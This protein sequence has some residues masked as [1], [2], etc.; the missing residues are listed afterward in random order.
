MLMAFSMSP[1]DSTSAARQ[2]LKPAPVRSRNSLTRCAGI[3]MAGCCVL[4]FFSFLVLESLYRGSRAVRCVCLQ[5]GPAHGLCHSAGPVEILCQRDLLTWI[6]RREERLF[7]Q[8]RELPAL[9]RALPLRRNLLPASL[10]AL[11]PSS[12]LPRRLPPN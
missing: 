11:T 5:N 6:P 1:A 4:I 12:H 10:T 8:A 2:S 7:P 9:P 3:C